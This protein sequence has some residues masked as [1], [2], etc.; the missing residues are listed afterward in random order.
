MQMHCVCSTEYLC[1]LVQSLTS[2]LNK[3]LCL[4]RF[5]WD[6]PL[7]FIITL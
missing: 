6:Y 7:I 4:S 2:T 5:I 1:V 3:A